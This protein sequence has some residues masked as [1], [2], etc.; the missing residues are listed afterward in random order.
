MNLNEIVDGLTALQADGLACVV[1][2]VNYL[3]VQVASVPVGRSKT[4]SQV[5]ACADRCAEAA[6]MGLRTSGGR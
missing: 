6:V 1:C 4:G 2:E 5:F 3:Y